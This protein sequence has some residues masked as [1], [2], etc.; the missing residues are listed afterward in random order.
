MALIKH[1]L[2][3]PL[4]L[5]LSVG[6][7][8]MLA[9]E[10]RYVERY[11]IVSLISILL[12][13]ALT[14]G[15]TMF[16]GPTH[17]ISLAS[18]AFFGVGVYTTAVIS[19]DYSMLVAASV[20]GII[21][22][23]L[24]L[25]IGLLTL[26]LKGVYF[27]LFTFGVSALIRHS[28][29]WWETHVTHTVGRVVSR[30]QYQDVYYYV[31]GI[32]VATLVVCYIVSQ[33]KFGL[34]LKAVG[35]NEEAA[36][37]LGI[38]VTLYKTLG[39]A[40]SAVFMGAIGAIYA[41][42]LGYIDPTIAFN[43]TFA[44]LPVVMA[45]FGGTSRLHGPIIGAVVF[46]YLREELITTYPEYFMLTI[47][48]T[49]IIVIMYLPNGLLGLFDKIMMRLV[50]IPFARKM[51]FR[52][53]VGSLARLYGPTLGTAIFIGAREYMSMRELLEDSIF[54]DYPYYFLVMAAIIIVTTYGLNSLFRLV[55][56]GFAR[57]NWN[58]SL[59][60]IIARLQEA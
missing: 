50:R 51:I 28:L 40:I 19:K 20:G 14:L 57:M 26:R 55:N 31:L 41:N 7:V 6:L 37:H 22:F 60:K 1:T 11:P 17:Y 36:S 34:A 49:L 10:P 21:S 59:R 9:L 56:K 23:V 47:G 46:T 25:L 32:T 33:T 38:N 18:A 4:F 30:P 8:A 52:L 27:I 54:I 43:P 35:E 48:L 15:W 24:A 58:L 16:S 44:F 29:G 2:E 13:V 39:F 45:I 5:S 53:K 42:R 3:R 12:F